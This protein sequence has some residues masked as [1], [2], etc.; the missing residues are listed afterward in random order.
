MLFRDWSTADVAEQLKALGFG[1]YAAR[2]Q[3]NEI[4]GAHLPRLTEEHL[5][6]M[7]VTSVGHRL[8][9]LRRFSDINSGRISAQ[10]APPP[11]ARPLSNP[12]AKKSERPAAEPRGAPTTPPRPSLDASDGSASGSDKPLARAGLNSTRQ[13]IRSAAAAAP[14]PRPHETF[15]ADG[16]VTCQYCGRLFQADTA[17]KHI[18]VCGKFNAGRAVAKK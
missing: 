5:K 18:P 12:P 7:G 15:A 11:P 3:A 2:F 17:K 6:E 13:S 1:Q 8:L 10:P 4:A 9:M 16:Q 14:A